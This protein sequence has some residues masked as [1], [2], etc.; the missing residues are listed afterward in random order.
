MSVVSGYV[1]GLAESR[2]LNLIEYARR[3]GDYL[4][5]EEDL[6]SP[7]TVDGPT[8]NEGRAAIDDYL[9]APVEVNQ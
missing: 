8:V 7:W 3:G 2:M 5:L 4:P 9:P 1:K 6:I